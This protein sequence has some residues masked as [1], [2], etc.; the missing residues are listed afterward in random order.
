MMLERD[1]LLG[2]MSN[3]PSK[4][5]IVELEP[6]WREHSDVCV[7]FY[8]VSFEKNEYYVIIVHDFSYK[9]WIYSMKKKDEVY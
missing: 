5:K 4:V 1:A 8:I 3:P 6:S 7:P 2:N 9:C